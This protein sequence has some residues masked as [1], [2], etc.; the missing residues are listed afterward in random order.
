MVKNVGDFIFI[1]DGCVFLKATNSFIHVVSK[2]KGTKKQK[3]AKK[4]Q[5]KIFKEIKTEK[6]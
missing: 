3:E 1:L 2:G 4:S 5:R 6:W